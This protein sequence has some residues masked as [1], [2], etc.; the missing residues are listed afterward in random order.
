MSVPIARCQYSIARAPANSMARSVSAG[1]TCQHRAS[2]RA[3]VGDHH[4]RWRYR[5]STAQLGRG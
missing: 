3:D 1:I 5:T 4:M 2:H